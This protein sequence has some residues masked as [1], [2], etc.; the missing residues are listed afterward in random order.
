MEKLYSY[1]LQ[2]PA[3][4]PQQIASRLY[5]TYAVGPVDE[6]ADVY[7]SCKKKAHEVIY[8]HLDF[9]SF[10]KDGEFVNEL[11]EK[12]D[13]QV[14]DVIEAEYQAYLDSLD[15]DA[16]ILS[17]EESFLMRVE[18]HAWTHGLAGLPD[19]IRISLVSLTR[20]A[21]QYGNFCVTADDSLLLKSYE[22]AARQTLMERLSGRNHEDILIYRQDLIE[23]L[24]LR[25]EARMYAFFERFFSILSSSNVITDVQN[26]LSAIV[27]LLKSKGVEPVECGDVELPED[28][29]DGEFRIFTRAGSSDPEAVLNEACIKLETVWN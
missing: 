19:A 11:P 26:R 23:Y 27:D 25:C 7:E 5:D 3:Y 20:C 29:F 6:A 14:T 16:I 4:A 21:G 15:M 13:P 28:F 2:S 17:A 8:R 1:F 10:K 9:A 24:E 18:I 22:D 12:F